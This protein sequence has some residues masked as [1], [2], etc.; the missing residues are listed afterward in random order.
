MTENTRSIL[1]FIGC[2][3]EIFPGSASQKEILDRF[4]AL[5]EAGKCA[6]F[7]PLVIV[8]S[9]SMAEYLEFF[10]EDRGGENTPESVAASRQAIIAEACKIDA[11]AFLDSWLEE[12][13]R[14]YAGE[15][16]DIIGQFSR[17]ETQNAL[18]LE[19]VRYEPSEVIIAKVP[20]KN[21]WEL[22]AWLPMGGFNDCPT[23]AEQVAVYKYWQAKYGA[24]PAIAT[25]DTW[26]MTLTT[27]PLTEEDAERLAKEQFA[28]C[29]DI[30][31][32]G[33]QTI[34]ALASM[35]KN[36]KAW[37]FWWD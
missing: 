36:S 9:D 1:D 12:Q 32:Q 17:E 16:Y 11:K 10:V 2:E 6:G 27:P 4:S 23:P 37:Y 7:S 3:Y 5:T 13:L 33:T 29:T 24:V 30:V 35:L 31:T 19:A 34:L 22:A 8:S 21:P 25:F 14:I 15:G 26:Q 28:F 20:T 18:T